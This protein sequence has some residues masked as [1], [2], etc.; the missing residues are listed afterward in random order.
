[1]TQAAWVVLSVPWAVGA[2]LLGPWWVT[3][4]LRVPDDEL[5]KPQRFSAVVA[6]GLAVLSIHGRL[7]RRPE[8]GRPER[9]AP[10]I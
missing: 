2:V 7:R 8:A 5:S 4:W 9:V 1:L 10:R 3:N 6:V